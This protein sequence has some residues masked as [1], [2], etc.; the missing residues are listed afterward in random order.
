M[1]LEIFDP[2][3]CCSTGVC[4]PN[5]NPALVQFASDLE[6]LKSKGIE[7]VRHNLS[8]EPA[9]FTQNELVRAELEADKNCLPIVLLD[10]QIATRGEYP[11]TEKL[12]SLTKTS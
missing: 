1:K 10:G 5:V 11:S 12:T 8:Q 7:I 3:M 6:T 4:G 2:P 9:A